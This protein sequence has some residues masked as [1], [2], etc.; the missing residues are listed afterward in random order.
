MLLIP[1]ILALSV[2]VGGHGWQTSYDV[3]KQF[4]FQ[5]EKCELQKSASK[6]E[7]IKPAKKN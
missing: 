6:Y 1:L 5:S 2:L 4:N 3:C 7:E